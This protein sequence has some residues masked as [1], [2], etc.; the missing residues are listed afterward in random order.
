MIWNFFT[1]KNKDAQIKEKNPGKEAL[2][3]EAAIDDERSS[4]DIEKSQSSDQSEQPTI[5]VQKNTFFSKIKNFLGLKEKIDQEQI[6]KLKELFLS[7]D[8]GNKLS[9]DLCKKIDK[10]YR[11]QNPNKEQL[12]IFIEDE[13]KKIIEKIPGK[14]EFD[15]NKPTVILMCGINGNGKTSSIGK[16]S[17][18]FKKNG[19]KVLLAAC[20]T[21]R[22]AAVEQLATWAQ[23]IDVEIVKGKEKSDPASVAF[24]ACQKAIDE[25]C[26]LLLIDTAGR[27]HNKENL[28]AELQKIKKITNK[29]A[30]QI[31]LHTVLVIDANVGHN[32]DQQLK[33]FQKE[34]GV[35]GLIFTKMDGTTKG[36]SLARIAYENEIK[37]LAVSFGEG[38]E[39][40][41]ELKIDFLLQKIFND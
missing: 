37:V 27:L 20:D 35:D 5:I 13:I 21:F 28:M 32:A 40:I 9:E 29:F 38:I 41:G 31:N 3:P 4:F 30:A 36:G 1:K 19:K 2:K 7:A 14:I 33:I 18:K 11:E 8:F 34:I 24:T 10:F 25:K 17:Y 12:Q 15:S 6:N 22:A 39:D 23:K 16:L 26:D